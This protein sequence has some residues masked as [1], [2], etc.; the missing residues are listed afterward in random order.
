MGSDWNQLF[1]AVDAHR[2]WSCR[3]TAA[4]WRSGRRDRTRP[5][6]SALALW[7]G[8]RRGLRLKRL[9]T[10]PVWHGAFR[11]TVAGRRVLGGDPQPAVPAPSAGPVVER[12][13]PLLSSRGLQPVVVVARGYGGRKGFCRPCSWDRVPDEAQVVASLLRLDLCF[14]KPLK[15]SGLLLVV[16]QRDLLPMPQNFLEAA[17]RCEELYS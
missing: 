2:Q 9:L 16:V 12:A 1:V 14:L 7:R 4:C 15:R 8:G 3:L 5:C 10:S 13:L 11:R 17:A 6:P